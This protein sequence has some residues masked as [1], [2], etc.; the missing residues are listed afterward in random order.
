MFP[1]KFLCIFGVLKIFQKLPDR[2]SKSS[3]DSYPFMYSS[4]FQRGTA[5]RHELTVRWRMLSNRIF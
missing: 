4:G 5:W 2:P 1:S 3:G